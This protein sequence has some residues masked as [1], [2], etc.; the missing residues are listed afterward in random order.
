MDLDN[1]SFIPGR[2]M[3]SFEYSAL[4]HSLFPF[5]KPHQFYNCA[6][7]TNYEANVN[8]VPAEWVSCK[9]RHGGLRSKQ[10]GYVVG[11]R[12]SAAQM[13]NVE[14]EGRNQYLTQKPFHYIHDAVPVTCASSI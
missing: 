7:E 1:P 13:L 8:I 11:Y 10:L 5:P 3:C 2:N 9:G 4:M 6:Q 12:Y 14:L